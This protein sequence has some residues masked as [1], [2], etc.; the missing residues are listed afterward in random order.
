MILPISGRENIY[1]PRALMLSFA[2][3][4]LTAVNGSITWTLFD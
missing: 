2:P 4:R 1:L 3:D